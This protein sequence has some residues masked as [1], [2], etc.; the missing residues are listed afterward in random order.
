MEFQ[1]RGKDN[2]CYWISTQQI[3]VENPV[4]MDVIA[5]LLIKRLDESHAE[6]ARQEQLLRD[7]LASARAASRTKSDLLSRMSHD[8]RTPMNAI[9]GMS[10]LGQLE[11][12]KESF[13]LTEMAAEINTIIFPETLERKQHY[14]IQR[15]GYG[16]R[17]ARGIYRA[18][19]QPL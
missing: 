8:I 2:A 19:F 7:A 15:E 10:T 12:V 11:L 6:K 4:D 16:N 14:E 17:N 9:I 13:D 18:D 5:I 3:N 1:H